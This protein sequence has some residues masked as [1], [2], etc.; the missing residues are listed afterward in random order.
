MSF[1]SKLLTILPLLR[2]KHSIANEQH[3]AKV[4]GNVKLAQVGHQSGLDLLAQLRLAKHQPLL[5]QHHRGQAL[6]VNQ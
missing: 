5:G 6:H 3:E 4:L 2:N 1:E